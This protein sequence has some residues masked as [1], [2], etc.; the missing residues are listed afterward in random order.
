[1]AETQTAER[2][3]S[4][5]TSGGNASTDA[6]ETRKTAVRAAAIAAASGATALAAKKAFSGRGSRQDEGE[7]GD[8]RPARKGDESVLTSMLTSSWESARGSLVPMLEDAATS[9][10]EYVARNAPDVVTEKLVPQFIRGFERGRKDSSG[11][12]DEDE[13]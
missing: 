6:H 8:K 5:E 10:G 12:G 11:G 1:M 7:G 9:A 13:E 3:Q 4:E 2:T